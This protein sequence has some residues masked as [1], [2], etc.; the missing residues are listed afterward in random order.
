M[1]AGGPGILVA[2]AIASTLDGPL[3]VNGAVVITDGEARLCF[4]L[5]ESFPPQCGGEAMPIVG[6]DLATLD[7]QRADNARWTASRV[8]LLGFVRDGVVVIDDA[9]LAAD[10]GAQPLLGDES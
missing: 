5:A 7:L 4:A 2:E 6:L 1:L 8:Q 9:A 3:L 10:G